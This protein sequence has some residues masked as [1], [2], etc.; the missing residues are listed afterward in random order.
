M[1][2]IIMFVATLLFL[3][4]GYP[5]A[6]SFGAAAI[7][8]GFI[9]VIAE[10][11]PDPTFLDIMEEFFLMFSMMPFRIYSMMTNTILMAIPLFILMG[12]ILQKSEVAERLLESMGLLFGR[13]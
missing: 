6:F 11:Q 9:G 10:L 8:F 3:L 1:I 7:F 4:L 13:V 2:G 5:V 12:I